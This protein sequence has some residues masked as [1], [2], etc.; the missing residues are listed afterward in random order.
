MRKLPVTSHP[1]HRPFTSQEIESLSVAQLTAGT[2]TAKEIVLATSGGVLAKIRSSNYV[3]GVSGWQVDSDGNAEFNNVTVRGTIYATAG[4][5]GGWTIGA[6][7]LTGGNA[8]LGST[9]VLTL[10]TSNDVAIMSA[11]DAT[12]R[13]WIGHATAGSAPFRVTKAGAVTATSVTVLGDVVLDTGGA[14]KTAS[15]GGRVEMSKANASQINF[16]DSANALIGSLGFNTEAGNFLLTDGANNRVRV[17]KGGDVEFLNAAGSIKGLWDESVS[18]WIWEGSAHSFTLGGTERLNIGA[19]YLAVTDRIL[20][21]VYP[22]TTAATALDSVQLIWQDNGVNVVAGL[23]TK[24]AFG[25]IVEGGTEYEGA[26]IGSYKESGSDTNSATAL[27]FATRGNADAGTGATIR[28]IVN[29]VGQLELWLADGTAPMIITSTTRIPNLN[30]DMVDGSH[31]SAFVT[32]AAHV[33]SLHNGFSHTGHYS[34]TTASAATLRYN[35]SATYLQLTSSERIKKNIAPVKNHPRGNPV[36]ALTPVWFE[37]KADADKGNPWYIGLSAEDVRG[38]FPEAYDRVPT[39]FL[40]GE[41]ENHE[42]TDHKAEPDLGRWDVNVVVS[43]LLAVVKEQ[44]AR[45]AYL[46]RAA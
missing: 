7:T 33:E 43:A 35:T 3:A 46:E 41:A 32:T 29:S 10:G 42:P 44:D 38:K 45:I 5:I 40:C 16:Y 28:G 22:A 25:Q 15:S 36:L 18:T 17:R 9:G 6:T 2:I 1:L 13:L 34:G 26:W 11:A 27:A 21:A 37:S 31:A 30:A 4:T 24:V 19:T 12:Y 14:F 23:G 20:R 8:T 39:C